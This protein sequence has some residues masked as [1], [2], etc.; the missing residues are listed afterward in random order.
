[1]KKILFWWQFLWL[2]LFTIGSNTA[3]AIDYPNFQEGN[4]IAK[5]FKFHTGEV[6]PELKIHYR[7]LG[8]PRAQAVLLLHGTTGSGANFLAPTF[9]DV[10]FGPGQ[11]LDATKYFII[12]PDSIGAGDSSKPSDG[13]RMK[14]PKYNYDDAVL[15]Q[16]LLITQA[17]N[18]NHLRVIIGNSMGGMQTWI[19]G[20]SHPTFSDLLVPMASMPS[21]MS[22]RNWMLRRLIIDSIRQDPQWMQGNY[23]EQPRSYQFASTFYSIATNGG[24]LGLQSKTPTSQAA[25]EYLNQALTR[26]MKG[27]AN[28][29]LY[30]WESSRD[31]DPS[32][33]LEKIKS[34][35]LAI[36]SLDDER[37]PPE[38]GFLEKGLQRIPHAQSFLIKATEKTTGHTTV[39][40]ANLWKE[41]FFKVLQ[42]TPPLNQ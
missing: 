34:R 9:A 2:T 30:Q 27:D 28:D 22:G 18:I 13:M 21:P 32:A 10:M 8:S 6:L 4:W 14:F 26:P 24:T 36:N 11:P 40:L 29:A 39:S 15:A 25:D 33:S 37:N 17:F 12:M 20:I 41:A 19:W 31:Y 7:T 42:A 3:M 23:V 38:L 16:Y 1:M 35:V 5:D